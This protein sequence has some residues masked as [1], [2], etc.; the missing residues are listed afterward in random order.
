V[1]NTIFE[2]QSSGYDV[3]AILGNHEHLLLAYL[4][5][6]RY[7]NLARWLA[8]GGDATL[9]S[10]GVTAPEELVELIEYLNTL[11]LY[12][13][14]DSHIFVHAGLDFTIEDPFLGEEAMLWKRSGE[15]DETKLY[16]KVL[17]SGQWR[18]PFV[19]CSFYISTAPK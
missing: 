17:V 1:R 19:V 9:K 12:R 16:G 2:L 13:T 6:P 5:E 8:N 10:Y 14:T 15:V 4:L 3:R 11:P 7:E 18:P